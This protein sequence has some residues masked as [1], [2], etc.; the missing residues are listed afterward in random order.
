MKAIHQGGH[1]LWFL[2]TSGGKEKL[3]LERFDAKSTSCPRPVPPPT[4]STVPAWAS[5][6]RDICQARG[7]WRYRGNLPTIRR[8][9]LE[10][11]SYDTLQFWG[12]RRTNNSFLCSP[13]VDNEENAKSRS[14]AGMAGDVK[15]GEGVALVEVE[16][17]E[18]RKR[19]THTHIIMFIFI[20]HSVHAFSSFKVLEES[21]H[22]VRV[23]CN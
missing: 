7:C 10:F 13:V 15:E 12:W 23:N 19:V 5:A 1:G 4:L 22:F 18:I 6:Q 11:R 9:S 20:M 14:R 17:E 21:P 8:S 3:G 16:E 2:S